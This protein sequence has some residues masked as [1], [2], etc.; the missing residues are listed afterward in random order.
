MHTD[1]CKIRIPYCKFEI[2][3]GIGNLIQQNC[4][5]KPIQHLISSSGGK[6][7]KLNLSKFSINTEIL[8]LY[9]NSK[10]M[11]DAEI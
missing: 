8:F 9:L 6:K 7:S 4:I 5:K 10:N 1:R 11:P 3:I 2:K